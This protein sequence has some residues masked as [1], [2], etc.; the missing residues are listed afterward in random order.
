MEYSWFTFD[1]DWV[2]VG[3]IVAFIVVTTFL[4]VVG[5]LTLGD[6][7]QFIGLAIGIILGGVG[8]ILISIWGPTNNETLIRD[9]TTARYGEFTLVDEGEQLKPEKE[10]TIR[11]NTSPDDYCVLNTGANTNEIRVDCGVLKPA[12][13]LEG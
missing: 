4:G 2:F 3:L 1:N 11:L 10:Y 12:P 5:L 6:F 8:L 13:Q 9:Q 7:G